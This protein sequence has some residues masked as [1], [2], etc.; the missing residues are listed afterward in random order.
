MAG[1]EG[2]EE[3]L[4]GLASQI[5]GIQAALVE[6]PAQMGHQQEQPGDPAFRVTPPPQHVLDVVTERNEGPDPYR[7]CHNLLLSLSRRRACARLRI[8]PSSKHVRRTTYP[9]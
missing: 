5:T 4:D 7:F 1:A 6:P 8:M 9:P 3:L 2:D